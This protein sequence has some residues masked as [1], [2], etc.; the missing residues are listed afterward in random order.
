MTGLVGAID[1][2]R[3]RL[4]AIPGVDEKPSRWGADPAFWIAGRE[5]VHCHGDQAEVRVTRSL[6]TDALSDPQVIRRTRT[7]DWVQVPIA[8]TDLIASLAERAVAANLI[9]R[10]AA[11]N[12]SG[13]RRSRRSRCHQ[14]GRALPYGRGP[15]G[16]RLPYRSDPVTRPWG[17]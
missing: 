7:S 13:S 12:T 17:P 16:T 5:F 10:R 6:M 4:L 2:L 8:A 9:G 15:P 14:R 11:P 1:A 3:Q